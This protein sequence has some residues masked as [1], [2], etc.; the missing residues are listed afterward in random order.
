MTTQLEGKTL[1]EAE[2]Q[3]EDFKDI[4][5]M[6]KEPEEFSEVAAFAGVHAF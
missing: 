3:F 1:A 5:T 2:G 6:G 4:V